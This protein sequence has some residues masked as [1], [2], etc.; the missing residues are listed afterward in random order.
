[1]LDLLP[2]LPAA[3]SVDLAADGAESPTTGI[4]ELAVFLDAVR[5]R[6]DPVVLS[7]TGPVTLDLRLLAE[8]WSPLAA[9]EE[10]T[11]RVVSAGEQMLAI[12]A[13]S[14]PDAPV[15][16]FLEEPGMSNSMHPTFPLTPAQVESLVQSSVAPLSARVM[17]GVQVDG[18][19]DWAM[20]MRTRIA[21]LGAPITARLESAAAELRQ[22][23][24][25]GGIIAWGA[26]P[27]DEPLGT[28][29]D[30]LWR[31][32]SALWAD[33]T[34]LGVDPMLLRE[35]SIITPA[36]GLGAFGLTQA[37]RVIQLT[38]DLSQ[39]VINQISGARMSIGA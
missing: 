16:L 14:I 29:S 18:R 7:V 12:A 31:R 2:T 11:R 38:T 19:A 21:V 17:V 36:A 37:E 27:V 8:G 22:F 24:E 1:M 34:T 3:P 15:V 35:R 32:L 10:A 5:G 30:R 33:L 28:G 6:V 39:R 25:G 13:A 20:L 26:V 23:L 4:D 9:M